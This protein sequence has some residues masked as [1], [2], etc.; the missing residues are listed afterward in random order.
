MGPSGTFSGHTQAFLSRAHVCAL[1]RH[2]KRCGEHSDGG[3]V[4]AWE[5]GIG[6]RQVH[7]LT[8]NRVLGEPLKS[9][10]LDPQSTK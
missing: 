10:W 8:N 1:A 6:L 2:R 7:H 4:S 9:F 3:A 5:T